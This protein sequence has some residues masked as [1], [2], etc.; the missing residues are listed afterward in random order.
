[1]TSTSGACDGQTW[2]PRHP[3]F[4]AH[5]TCPTSATTIA[6]DSVPFGV[7]T[8]VVSSHSGAFFGTRF[9]KNE[10]PPAPSRNRCSITGRPPIVAS[11]GS[12]TAS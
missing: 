6:F 9:W 8:V 12:R 7:D 5:A 1:M 10:S 2:N 11:S 3:R 4:T